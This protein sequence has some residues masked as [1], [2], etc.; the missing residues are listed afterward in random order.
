MIDKIYSFMIKDTNKSEQLLL[1]SQKKL[2][3]TD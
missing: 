2:Q 1:I 3:R